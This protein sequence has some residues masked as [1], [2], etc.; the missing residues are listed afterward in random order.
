MSTATATQHLDSISLEEINAQA[1]LQTRVDRKYLMHRSEAEHL[2]NNLTPGHRVMEIGGIRAL[3]Y[4]SV[5]FDTPDLVSYFRAAHG[6]RRRF[7]LR[8]RVYSDTG[9]SFLEAKVKGLRGVTAKD[10]VPHAADQVMSLGDSGREYAASVMASV[11]LDPQDAQGLAPS[12]GTQYQRVTVVVP[13]GAA[14]AASRVTVD[15]ELRWIRHGD[16]GVEREAYLPEMAIIET[17][18]SGSAGPVDRML[19]SRGIRPSSSS[20]YCL[21]IAALTPGL[22]K[23]KW[24]RVVQT[25][26][27]P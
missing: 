18:T 12:L 2:L 3:K 19:W 5:Y 27:R 16:N 25:W 14:A 20:K 11:G 21:G 13:A 26:F 24:N 22:Q 17:K 10:R 1:R 9:A 8:T 7:K 6:R 4:E 23:N 15:T